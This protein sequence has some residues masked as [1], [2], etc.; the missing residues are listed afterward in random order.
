MTNT[1]RRVNMHIVPDIIDWGAHDI[2]YGAIQ[3]IMTILG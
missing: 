1:R 3:E 2:A